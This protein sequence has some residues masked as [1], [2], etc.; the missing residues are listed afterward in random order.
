MYRMLRSYDEA[1]ER[2]A[3]VTHPARARPELMAE[4]PNVWRSWDTRKYGARTKAWWLDLYVA[5]D[6]FSRYVVGWMVAT[7]ET[8][9]LAEELTTAAVTA[10]GVARG[11]GIHA[12][13]GTSMTSKGVTELLADL[14]VGRT[15]SRPQ[16]SNDSPFSEAVNS[17]RRRPRE[18]VR[19]HARS[20]A[21]V[22]G[23]T[24]VRLLTGR[25][26]DLNTDMPFELVTIGDAF[27]RLDR[28]RR[29]AALAMEWIRPG[30]SIALSW[31]SVPWAGSTRGK[32]PPPSWCSTGPRLADPCRTSRRTW[33]RQ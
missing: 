21:G 6:I 25:A 4:K 9:E 23:A 30:G 5:I 16:V 24:R 32:E 14:G 3:Q 31:T 29:I 15:H 7:T 27:H 10:Q 11:E 2:R 26:E 19:E 28:W 17:R 13:R 20:V 8:A 18:R 1:R 22:R 12:D 33:P